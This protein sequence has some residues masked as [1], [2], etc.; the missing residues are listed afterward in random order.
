MFLDNCSAYPSEKEL[1]DGT[2]TIKF[3]PPNVTAVLQPVD[4]EVLEPIKRVYR[5][6]NLRDLVTQTIF[7]IQDF[8]K[9]IDMIKVVDSV[10]SAWDTCSN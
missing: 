2:I 7:T 8:L 5:K 3:L 10:A 9:R 6:S 1:L 4:Q